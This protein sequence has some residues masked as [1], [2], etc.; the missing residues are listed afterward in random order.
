[1]GMGDWPMGREGNIAPLGERFGERSVYPVV[2]RS[3]VDW[4][5]CIPAFLT[6]PFAMY[7]TYC[8]KGCLL[9][10]RLHY[11]LKE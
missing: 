8:I 5:L 4:V 3:K 9:K 1:M 10:T 7:I 6:V 11:I 2:A